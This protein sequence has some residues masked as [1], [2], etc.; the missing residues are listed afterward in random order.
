MNTASATV[1][2]KLYGTIRQLFITSTA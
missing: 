1:T 2:W